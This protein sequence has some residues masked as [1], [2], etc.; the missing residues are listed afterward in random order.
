MT[1]PPQPDAAPLKDLPQ[2]PFPDVPL[3]DLRIMPACC[4]SCGARRHV[5]YDSAWQK[6]QPV[7]ACPCCGKIGTLTASTGSLELRA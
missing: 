5:A 2:R 1:P 7:L 3:P 4:S 6:A